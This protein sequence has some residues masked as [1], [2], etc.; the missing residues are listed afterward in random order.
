MWAASVSG[1]VRDQESIM[2]LNELNQ[3][4]I[5]HL[6]HTVISISFTWGQSELEMSVSSFSH[7]VKSEK[8]IC[9]QEMV[10]FTGSPSKT[11]DL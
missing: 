4:I 1:Q 3:Y 10:N 7:L 6:H 9:I 2:E 8:S 11:H 5:W